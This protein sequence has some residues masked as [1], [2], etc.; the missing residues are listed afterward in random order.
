MIIILITITSTA[1][2]RQN[3]TMS[4]KNCAQQ[5]QTNNA[6]VPYS[7]VTSFRSYIKWTWWRVISNGLL[8]HRTNTSGPV[9]LAQDKGN[10]VPVFNQV[11]H[12]DAP[13]A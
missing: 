8:L 4:T 1:L 6:S 3:Y 10:T 12:E 13:S 9:H 5:T 11:R 7:C 2:L